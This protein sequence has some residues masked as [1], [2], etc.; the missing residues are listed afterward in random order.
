MQSHGWGCS[1]QRAGPLE[2]E[3]VL[4]DESRFCSRVR[5]SVRYCGR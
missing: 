4:A 3:Q 5:V 1:F 2:K